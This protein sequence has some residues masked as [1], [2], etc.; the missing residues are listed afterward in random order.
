LPDGRSPDRAAVLP[1]EG[2]GGAPE[3]DFTLREAVATG[4][5]RHLA[6]AAAVG[7]FSHQLM[8]QH[9]VANAIDQGITPKV[10]ATLMSV[11]GLSNIVGKLVMGMIS[12]RFGRMRLLVFSLGLAAVMMFWLFLS[13]DLWMFYIFAVIFGWAYGS[14]IPMYPALVGD[15][16]GLGSVGAIF[17]LVLTSNFV[18]GFFG[19]FL[20]GYIY[21]I[22]GGYGPAFLLGGALLLGGVVSVLTLKVPESMVPAAGGRYE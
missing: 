4:A 21:D 2:G 7:A 22:T 13:R 11:I 14:W 15:I 1:P 18:G 8:L 12:D 17:G 16:F 20:T 3:R 19:G 5:F 6:L 9:L 10:A